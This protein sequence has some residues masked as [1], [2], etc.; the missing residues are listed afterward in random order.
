M[1]AQLIVIFCIIATALAGAPG[2]TKVSASV[3][4]TTVNG[5]EGLNVNIAAPF[6]FNDYVVGFRYALGDLRRAPESLFAKRTFDTAG[7][8]KVVVD[9]DYNLEDKVVSVSTKWSSDTYGLSVSAEADSKDRLKS[10]GVSKDTT[11]NDNKL[12][13]TGAYDLLKKKFNGESSFE[14]DSTTLGLKYNSE[15]RDPVLS[16]TRCIDAKN[17]V[18]PS[19]SLKN[20]DV[21]YGYTRKW[22]GG[23]LKS[24]LFPGEKVEVEWTDNGSQGTWTTTAEVPLDNRA[25]T[26]VSFGRDWN[27]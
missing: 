18:S 27:Y 7:E 17:E 9:S 11:V 2:S 5:V 23:A 13:L 14:V 15:D 16:V 25:N 26:K 12:T 22:E 19:V 24:K 20:G 3:K 8:G 4:D 6:K 10:V 21:A 1:F